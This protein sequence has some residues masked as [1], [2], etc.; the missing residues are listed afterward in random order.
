MKDG[1]RIMASLLAIPYTKYMSA[2]IC[3]D[4][5]FS[6]IFSGLKMYQRH[7]VF[8][9][10][11]IEVF[12]HEKSGHRG[13]SFNRLVEPCWAYGLGERKLEGGGWILRDA[14][15]LYRVTVEF[16]LRCYASTK[17]R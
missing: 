2:Y 8:S 9:D 7:M 13:Y 1:E 17:K 3:D 4:K 6:N 15:G 16:V 5:V 10:E 11:E 14:D 12:Y